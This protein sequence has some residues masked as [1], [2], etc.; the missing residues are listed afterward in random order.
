MGFAGL[1]YQGIGSVDYGYNNGILY[2]VGS[3]TDMAPSWSAMTWTGSYNE[4]FM[5]SRSEGVLTFRTRDFFGMIDGLSLGMQLQEKNETGSIYTSNGAGIG[6]SLSYEITS[7]FQIIG[8]YS[9]S[10]R[11]DEQQNV[12]K[13][14]QAESW[15]IGAKYD[16]NKIYLATVYSETRNT[17]RTGTA[18]DA[19]FANKS[20]NMEFLAQYLFL[21]V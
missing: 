2:D 11:T 4:N 6:Y 5:N 16:A 13:G 15:A 14:S 21:Q 10:D 18:G 8:A 3:L 12:G 19:G 9:N 1:K 17:T 20:R 7:G